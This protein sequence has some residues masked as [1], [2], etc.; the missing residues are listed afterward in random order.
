MPKINLVLDASKYD[1]FRLCEARYNYAYN[2]NIRQSGDKAHQ[3]DRGTLCHV[4]NEMY[5]ETLK[6]GGRY[7]DAV[8]SSLNKIKEAGVILTDLDP[9]DINRVANIMEEYYDYWRV[10][11]QMFEIVAVESPFLYLLYSDDEVNIYMSGKIDLIVSDNKYKNLPYD[12]KSQDRFFEVDR[13]SNQF[14]NYCYATKSEQ[15]I[16]NR[17]GFQKN[18]K[19]E[20]RFKRVP[21]SYDPIMLEEW[22]NNVVAVIMHYINCVAENKWPMNET[23]CMK[24]NRQCEYYDICDSSGLPAKNYK[25]SSDYIVVPE[26]DVTR[27]MRKASQMLEDAKIEKEKGNDHTETHS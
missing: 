3:L 24:Y 14:K 27:S 26:W 17:I 25:I 5:Y 1:M 12:H 18:F 19:P 16:V 9:D 15:L 2:L 22:K 8:N 11:D 10:A 20:E 23:S 21:V 4:G 6:N 7:E 13:M